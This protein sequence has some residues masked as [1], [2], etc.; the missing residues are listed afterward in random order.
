MCRTET[1]SEIKQ[2][3]PEPTSA[4]LHPCP[5]VIAGQ[6]ALCCQT[7]DYRREVTGGDGENQTHAMSLQP[8]K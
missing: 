6:S 4:H 7:A 2:K 5:P 3:T 8:L 1:Q